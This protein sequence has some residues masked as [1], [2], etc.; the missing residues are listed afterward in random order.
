MILSTAQMVIELRLREFSTPGPGSHAK[1]AIRKC[2]LRASVLSVC[3]PLAIFVVKLED[4]WGAMES[5]GRGR[6]VFEGLTGLPSHEKTLFRFLYRRQHSQSLRRSFLVDTLVP[7]LRHGYND[8]YSGVLRI[9]NA[10][11]SCIRGTSVVHPDSGHG[12]LGDRGCRQAGCLRAVSV[13]KSDDLQIPPLTAMP[14]P[15][16]LRAVLTYS[17]TAES[18]DYLGYIADAGGSDDGIP[19]IVGVL[20]DSLGRVIADP[21]SRMASLP[22]HEVLR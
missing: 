17:D 1:V 10:C 12:V 2:G 7:K 11:G 5:P 4:I 21:D 20:K 8:P 22:M 14:T 19:P 15:H 9:S 3:G 16:A 13:S 18:E 6:N